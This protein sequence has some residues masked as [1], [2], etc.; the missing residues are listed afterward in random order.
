MY[1]VNYNQGGVMRE[2]QID[3]VDIYY[4]QYSNKTSYV[5]NHY[6]KILNL[7]QVVK[8]SYLNSLGHRMIEDVLREKWILNIDKLNNML[9]EDII[10]ECRRVKAKLDRTDDK[11]KKILLSYMQKTL[12]RYIAMRKKD[13]IKL[14]RKRK[15]WWKKVY[16]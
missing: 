14:V 5:Y 8:I 9:T 11:N 10:E 12:T 6:R 7:P 13:E 3:Q 2:L 15:D 1:T 4:M 16:G